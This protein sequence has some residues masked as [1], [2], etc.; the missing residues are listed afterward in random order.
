MIALPVGLTF[1]GGL[2]W[3]G[4]WLARDK[5]AFLVAV[6]AEAIAARH[7]PDAEP[8]AADVM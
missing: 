5:E 3:F 6:V 2:V 1:G 8:S 4:R 7:A